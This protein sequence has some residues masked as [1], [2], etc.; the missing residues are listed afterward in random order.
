MSEVGASC[1][2]VEGRKSNKGGQK[3]REV[4]KGGKEKKKGGCK[5]EE[6]EEMKLP[7]PSINHL[8]PGNSVPILGPIFNFIKLGNFFQKFSDIIHGFPR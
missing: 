5:D 6:G 3:S 1:R 2:A 4:K 8:L 7:T